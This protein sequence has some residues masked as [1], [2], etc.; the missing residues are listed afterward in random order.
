MYR[1]IGIRQIKHQCQNLC[2]KCVTLKPSVLFILVMQDI[3]FLYLH[4]KKISTNGQPRNLT[5]VAEVNAS[6]VYSSP[7]WKQS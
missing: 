2:K 1:Q 3:F 4:S 7:C 6:S 5:K